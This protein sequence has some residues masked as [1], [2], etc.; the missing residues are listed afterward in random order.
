TTGRC[1]DRGT[2][3]RGI[4]AAE[5]FERCDA[6]G[7]ARM[8]V[9][10]DNEKIAAPYLD[11]R[12]GRRKYRPPLFYLLSIGRRGLLPSRDGGLFV[13]FLGD[14]VP[15]CQRR[16]D[17]NAIRRKIESGAKIL[18]HMMILSRLATGKLDD[19]A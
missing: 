8:A 4:A 17:E 1:L 5:S 12:N 14:V 9:E 15:R 10:I 16:K 13:K 18:I 6:I 19:A 3:R 2:L 7:A 11:A